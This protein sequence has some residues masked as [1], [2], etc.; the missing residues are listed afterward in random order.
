MNL[1]V[2]PSAWRRSAIA[3]AA[4]A[5]LG[6]LGLMYEKSQGAGPGLRAAVE[7]DMR[8]VHQLDSDWNVG[9][10]SAKV[11]LNDSYDAL[12]AP[13]K[14]IA[15]LLAR[16]ERSQA[17][18]GAGVDAELAALRREFVRK[19]DLVDNFKSHNSILRN[20]LRYLPAAAEDARAA[21]LAE[22]GVDPRALALAQAV[23]D[24]LDDAA[25]YAV[26]PEASQQEALAAAIARVEEQLRA[27]P[28]A[29]AARA[30]VA[31][32]LNHARTVLRQVSDE[33]E[34][35]A[36]ILKVRT[37]A[38][39]QVTNAAY[40]GF[41]ARR[42]LEAEHWR[43][44]LV[45]YSAALLMVVAW[46]GWR[47]RQSYRL[48]EHR[49]KERT[50]ELADALES[51]HES[52]AQLIQS[53]K[54]SSL[55]QMVAGVA[56]EINTPLAYVRSS[57]ETVSEQ[58]G[59]VHELVRHSNALLAAL[60]GQAP[61]PEVL[62]SHYQALAGIAVAFEQHGIVQELRNLSREGLHGLDQIGEIVVNL[63]DFSRLDR[64]KTMKFDL[65]EGLE[66]TLNIARGALKG[67]RIVKHYRSIPRVECAP[68]Q[69]NQVFLNLVTNAAQAIGHGDG[70]ITLATSLEGG[71][72]R[73]DV[74]DNGA[75]IAPENIA[76]IFDPFFTTKEIGQGTGLGLSIVYKIVREHGGTISVESLLGQGTTFTVRLPACKEE[77]VLQDEPAE[78]C[79]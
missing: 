11:G 71:M 55:G 18:Q 76:R 48:L 74:Q 79:A 64:G 19:G 58:L 40:E 17:A 68:S 46:T 1:H 33:G 16:I 30:P 5:A 37:V 2:S 69:V 42:S 49:V 20:S 34:L 43:L 75:G 59:D 29:G 3:A 7:S 73:V 41:Y 10:M 32:F 9:V 72:V 22:R 21:L 36:G 78:A 24:S 25:R 67:C 51:L 4:V 70:V 38:G 66:S 53:E 14:E 62:Q 65:R 8:R 35:L 50:R 23:T 26:I 39:I 60:D 45:A 6:L 57:L 77:P 54:M 47:L 13:Q 63:K 31:N 12:V 56:H 15:Q 28:E 27:W 52:E 61:D 44:A